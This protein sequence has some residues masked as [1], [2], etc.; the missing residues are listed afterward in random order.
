MIA[1]LT[2]Y[3]GPT[4]YRGSR[5]KAYT[6]SGRFVT[7]SYDSS[8]DSAQ[9]HA[10]AAQ[11]LCLKMGWKGQL[12]AGGIKGGYAFVFVEAYNKPENVA[13]N[14]GACDTRAGEVMVEVKTCTECNY[15][16]NIKGDLAKHKAEKHGKK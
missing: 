7:V 8:L 11:A 12:V 10:H 3:L 2:K 1:I 13:V 6:E 4:N 15:T 16:T 5:I 14:V 9:A